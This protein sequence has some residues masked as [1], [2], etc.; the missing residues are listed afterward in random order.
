[1]KNKVCSRCLIEKAPVEFNK[2]RAS[3][4]GLSSM[5]KECNKANCRINYLKDIKKHRLVGRLYYRNHLE[6]RMRYRDANK[7]KNQ[8]YQKEY[9]TRNK[10]YFNLMEKIRKLKIQARLKKKQ[11]IGKDVET[12]DI[13]LKL[14]DA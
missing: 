9:R 6:E 14:I 8:A 7:E 2:D 5:C 3:K 11:Q 10:N 12:E 1:M 13:Q 4:D